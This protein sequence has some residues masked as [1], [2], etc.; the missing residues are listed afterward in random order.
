MA[1]F[2][3]NIT[4]KIDLTQQTPD[5]GRNQDDHEPIPLDLRGDQLMDSCLPNLV[6]KPTFPSQWFHD[7]PNNKPI[8]TI[9]A[10]T[11]EKIYHELKMLLQNGQWSDLIIAGFM[12][13][14]LIHYPHEFEAELSCR[15]VSFGRIIGEKDQIVD[16]LDLIDIEEV[17]VPLTATED[18]AVSII[19]LRSM[20]I[21]LCSI[22]R[23]AQATNWARYYK[24][25]T[26]LRRYFTQ[27]VFDVRI[28]ELDLVQSHILRERLTPN[29]RKIIAMLDMFLNFF[30]NVAGRLVRIATLSSRYVGCEALS[31]FVQV[32][33]HFD[34][35]PSNLQLMVSTSSLMKSLDQLTKIG[36]ELD[37]EYGYFSYQLEFGLVQR[38]AY[39]S[40]SNPDIYIWVNTIGAIGGLEQSRN[41]RWP[42][43]TVRINEVMLSA[44]STGLRLS[45]SRIG[46]KKYLDS[47]VERMPQYREQLRA[48]EEKFAQLDNTDETPYLEMGLNR[49][50]AMVEAVVNE[51]ELYKGLSESHIKLAKSIVEAFPPQTNG[52][53]GFKV[54]TFVNGLRSC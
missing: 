51:L 27:Y 36:Q 39:S 13:K 6:K 42:D 25:N 16:P 29:Y 46:T 26:S 44:I 3:R 21:A 31:S 1:D 37:D 17:D 40:E 32:A 41:A 50:E 53:I 11:L 20:F 10:G 47:K 18:Q 43:P 15:W 23:P 28:V 22:Y 7:H 8:V 38:S 52:S 4:K 33:N 24:I 54:A 9:A 5:L 35:P 30:P 12:I 45:R 34:M 14:F 19:E 48:I 2:S 49:Y